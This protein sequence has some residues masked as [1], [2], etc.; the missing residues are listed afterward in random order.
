MSPKLFSNGFRKSKSN[1]VPRLWTLRL[2]TSS[3]VSWL[4]A[5]LSNSN[6]GHCKRN[7]ETDR[8]RGYHLCCGNGAGAG[9]K[10]GENN[11]EISAV[12][13][14]EQIVG[15]QPRERELQG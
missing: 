8:H 1:Y 6:Y 5:R 4:W 3:G 10:L 9:C 11:I 12:I 7:W 14:V 15:R 13:A 2:Q